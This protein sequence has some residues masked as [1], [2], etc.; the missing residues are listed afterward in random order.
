[1]P[2]KRLL[3]T[4]SEADKLCLEGYSR[5]HGISLAEAIRQDIATLKKS[6]TQETYQKLAQNTRGLWRLGDGPDYQERLRS[7]WQSS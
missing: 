7:E 5:I 2:S 6:A 3:I 1:M 4:L